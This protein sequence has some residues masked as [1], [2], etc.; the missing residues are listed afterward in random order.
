MSRSGRQGGEAGPAEG[1]SAVRDLR[2]K[3]WCWQ[4]KEAI[5]LIRRHWQSAPPEATTLA[6]A[7]GIYLI[8]TE[9]ASNSSSPAQFSAPR[10]RMADL[11]GV[12]ERTLL[13]YIRA[14]EALGLLQ[15]EER[16]VPGDESV[17]LPNAY[18]LLDPPAPAGGASTPP[19]QP[20]DTATPEG[21]A[22][23]PPGE[24]APLSRP[25]DTPRGGRARAPRAGGAHA[26]DREERFPLEKPTAEKQGGFQQTADQVWATAR[27]TLA[28]ELTKANY[29]TWVEGL[30]AIGRSEHGLTLGAP[31]SYVRDWVRTR[32]RS[33]I[34]QAVAEAVGRRLSVEFVL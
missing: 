23:A 27:E 31:S 22:P 5:R 26:T 17:Q 30:Q 12:S 11:A 1:A 28:R 9:L 21:V 14:F 15:V 33:V 3:A 2:S 4:D 20:A 7:L 29:S 18:A 16:R 24:T 6:A 32:L 25:A 19:G 34:E 8:L 13:R 10:R